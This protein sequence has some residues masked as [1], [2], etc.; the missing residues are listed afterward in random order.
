MYHNIEVTTNFLLTYYGKDGFHNFI[1]RNVQNNTFLY[2]NE[3]KSRNLSNQTKVQF[4][5]KLKGYDFNTIIRKTSANVKP[6]VEKNYSRDSDDGQFQYRRVDAETDRQTL[7]KAAQSMARSER[8]NE[9]VKASGC[10]CTI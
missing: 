10:I 6:F 7:A 2:I 3:E 4:F 1:D 8:D 5:G 9:I